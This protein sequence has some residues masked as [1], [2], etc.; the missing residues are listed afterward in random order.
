VVEIYLL[1]NQ[2]RPHVNMSMA[3]ESSPGAHDFHP[4]SF[5]SRSGHQCC[6]VFLTGFRWSGP[7]ISV[8]TQV[9]SATEGPRAGTDV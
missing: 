7:L 3:A 8:K 4:L 2:T 1:L 9:T 5:D 6:S